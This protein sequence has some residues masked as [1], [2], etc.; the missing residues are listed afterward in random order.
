[1]CVF[2]RDVKTRDRMPTREIA[3]ELLWGN[4]VRR[5]GRPKRRWGGIKTSR[6]RKAKGERE[7]RK[8]M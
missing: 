3:R 5:K 4:E 8:A 2:K 1:V 7:V 6:E